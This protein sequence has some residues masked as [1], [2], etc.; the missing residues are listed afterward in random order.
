DAEADF[1]REW[2]TARAR[3]QAGRQTPAVTR[4][5][6]ARTLS[7]WTGIPLTTLT[8]PERER[9]LELEALLARRV[10]GQDP[11][12]SAVARAIRRGRAGLKE[13]GR[14]VGSF[15]FLGPT[16]VG[17]TEL[18]KA[19]AQALFGTEEALLRFDMTEFAERHTMSRLTGSA[20]G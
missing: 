14:P 20:P 3:W 12:V 2:E 17:K 8:R 4:E 6:V 13:P 18:C 11:A 1:R 7:Q 16:G 19:L 5:D 9:L 15:L 10:T